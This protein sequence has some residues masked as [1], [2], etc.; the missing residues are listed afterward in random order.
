MDGHDDRTLAE[1]VE[2][3]RY[4]D[5]AGRDFSLM[6]DRRSPEEPIGRPWEFD[7]VF[8]AGERRE[9]RPFWSESRHPGKG[10]ED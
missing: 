3:G 4:S 7:S 9:T 1:F 6:I 10:A 2:I 8:C 5:E